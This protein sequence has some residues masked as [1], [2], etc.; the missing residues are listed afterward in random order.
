MP[1]TIINC[2]QCRQNLQLPP[3]FSGPAVLCPTC[4]AT[5]EVP[6]AAAPGT[7]APVNVAGRCAY[8]QTAIKDDEARA[9]CQECHAEYHTDCWNENGGCAMYGCSAVPAIEPRSSLEIPVSYWGQEKKPCP[10][11]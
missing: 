5:V 1:E 6:A 7:S 4:N 3:G 8:C 9:A 2:P 10:A 11:C